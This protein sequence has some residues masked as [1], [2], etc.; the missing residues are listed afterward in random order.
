MFIDVVSGQCATFEAGD[1]RN[2]L[3]KERDEEKGLA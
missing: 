1:F 2:D 3:I